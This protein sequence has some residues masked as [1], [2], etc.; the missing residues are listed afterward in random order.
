MLKDTPKRILKG[1]V[2]L[3]EPHVIVSQQVK[4]VSKT[5]FQGME[6]AAN[7]AAAGSALGGA[8]AGLSDGG[9]IVPS[10]CDEELGM[11]S[12]TFEGTNIAAPPGAPTLDEIISYI[13]GQIDQ[14]Y[15]AN[16]PEVMKPQI[17]KDGL[18]LEGTI[19]Y[20]FALPP[21]TPFGIL[22][23]LLRL[24]EFGHETVEF[25]PGCEDEFAQLD[26]T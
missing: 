25:D 9:T 1:I 18:E 13:Q 12:G 24:S 17:S 11:P 19:P 7:M 3:T 10:A 21:L 2:E 26:N 8:L 20:L 23:L 14:N 4:K 6:Q 5:V 22:Y 15:P 16:F